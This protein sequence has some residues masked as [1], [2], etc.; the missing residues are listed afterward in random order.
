MDRKFDSEQKGVNTRLDQTASVSELLQR[1]RRDKNEVEKDLKILHNSS[2]ESSFSSKENNLSR[3][4]KS[5]KYKNLKI[6]KLSQ[7]PP[8]NA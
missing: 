6:V 7:S 2:T 5:R 3:F 4:A 8:S 1:M